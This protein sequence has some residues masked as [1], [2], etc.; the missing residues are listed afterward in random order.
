VALEFRTNQPD[1]LGERACVLGESII[2]ILLVEDD[3]AVAGIGA[4]VLR[5]M[6]H[7]VEVANNG[8]DAINWLAANFP[9]VVIVDLELP[10]VHGTEVLH[11]ARELHPNAILMA[12]SGYP[13]PDGLVCDVILPKPYGATSIH[14]CIARVRVARESAGQ[15]TARPIVAAG[16]LPIGG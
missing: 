9:E 2:Q 6:G 14:E 7:V 13:L 4:L 16:P 8:H 15:S 12:T 10:R 5:R 3:Q 11:I 1:T